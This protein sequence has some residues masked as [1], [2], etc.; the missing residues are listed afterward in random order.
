MR[1]L[2]LIGGLSWASTLEYYR[3]I[4]TWV[5]RLGGGHSSAKMVLI[6]LDFAEIVALQKQGDWEQC[7][8]LLGRAAQS[9]EQAGAQ[10][11]VVC[12]NTMHKVAPAVQ[13]SCKLPLLHVAHAVGATLQNNSKLKVGLLGTLFTMRQSFYR[14][15]FVEYGCEMVLPDK[16]FAKGINELIFAELTQGKCSEQAEKTFA[17]TVVHLREK[18]CDS[19][20]LAC[21]ELMLLKGAAHDFGIPLFDSTAI[22]AECVARW[23]FFPDDK[24]GVFG[25]N[26]SL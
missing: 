8:I 19:V 11:V 12:S 9:L 17:E 3:L 26:P 14:D 7:G 24:Y 15:A 1:T 10:C 21:T 6:S 13:A 2:G 20:L 23:A 18:G 22:H 25:K 4:N 16:L 5:A